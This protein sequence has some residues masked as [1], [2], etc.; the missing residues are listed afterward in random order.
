[1]ALE[2]QVEDPVDHLALEVQAEDP[3]DRL[4]LEDQVDL[5]LVEG[6]SCRLRQARRPLHKAQAYTQ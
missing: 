5:R 2:V 4:A 3:E 1:M 6:P